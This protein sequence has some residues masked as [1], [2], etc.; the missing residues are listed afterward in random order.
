[1]DG[2][3]M[4]RE[5]GQFCPDRNKG[6]AVNGKG[7]PIDVCQCCCQERQQQQFYSEM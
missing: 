7:E 2:E 1:M 6:N 3:F 5:C 4:C